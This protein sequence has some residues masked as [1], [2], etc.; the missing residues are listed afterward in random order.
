M[1]E[2]CPDSKGE[3]HSQLDIEIG[4]AFREQ[5]LVRPIAG[6]QGLRKLWCGRNHLK[7]VM[8]KF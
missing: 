8:Q 5:R 6:G 7:R 2:V 4:L 1:T 3:R